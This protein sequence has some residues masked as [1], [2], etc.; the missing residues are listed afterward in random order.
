MNKN[1]QAPKKSQ[2]H[3]ATAQGESH[4]LADFRRHIDALF[5]EMWTKIGT[6]HHGVSGR[7]Y[8][9]PPPSADLAET[10]T[11]LEFAIEL[12]GMDENDVEVLV[13]DDRLV[14]RGEKKVEK[15]EKGRDYWLRE[16]AY[17]AFER[18]FP[19]PPD[20]N[21]KGTKAQ[22]EKGV[23]TVTVPRKAGTRKPGKKVAIKSK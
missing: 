20:A 11:A 5:E 12:P 2:R 3:D 22:L 23:L 15:E 18:S 9:G 10:A 16:R 8:T 1:R 17:G 4:M 7:A 13:S 21:G 14:I 19:L 6:Q